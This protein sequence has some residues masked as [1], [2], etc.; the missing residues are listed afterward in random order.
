MDDLL[1]IRDNCATH[2]IYYD[3][4]EPV[5]SQFKQLASRKWLWEGGDGKWGWTVHRAAA[6]GHWRRAGRGKSC[7]KQGEGI[8]LSTYCVPAPGIIC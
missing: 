7:V 4:F 5:L 8:I 3:L 1:Y 2:Q 6:G